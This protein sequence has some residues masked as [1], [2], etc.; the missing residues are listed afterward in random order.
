MRT[1]KFALLTVLAPAF[2]AGAL[3]GAAYADAAGSLRGT[4]NWLAIHS[5]QNTKALENLRNNPVPIIKSEGDWNGEE[6]ETPG[7]LQRQNAQ[8]A[9]ALQNK[10][11]NPV[12]LLPGSGDWNGN[13]R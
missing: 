8:N 6:P 2:V 13:N 7:W 5:A 9:R 4:T 1:I 3:S 11:N 12:L 10:R